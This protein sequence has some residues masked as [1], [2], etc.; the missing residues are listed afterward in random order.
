MIKIGNVVGSGGG[1]RDVNVIEV[2]GLFVEGDTDGLD[3]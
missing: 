3:F 2:N 1:G